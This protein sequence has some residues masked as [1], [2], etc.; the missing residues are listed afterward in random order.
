VLR[1]IGIGVLAL[2]NAGFAG[3]AMAACAV[4]TFNL[5]P[6][7]INAQNYCVDVNIHVLP[8]V[9]VW[10]NNS[11]IQ[12]TMNGADGNN[13]ATAAS[14][15]SVINNVDAKVDAT[16]TGVLPDPIV[17]GGGINFFIFNGGTAASAVAAI[18]ADAY[19]PAG[20]AV[21]RKWHSSETADPAHALGS[22]QTI[23]ASTGVNTS[24]ATKPIVYASDSPG[25]NPLPL[26]Y[27]LL[28]TYTIAP[29]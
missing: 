27:N 3:S 22:T 11:S 15:L 5:D 20:A 10:A 8:S 23:I 9:S 6:H 29:I 26:G 17:A 18:T 16:V 28:V 4:S 13:S 24:I 12:L 25:E 7:Q 1:N 14:S 2:G 19:A 21:W